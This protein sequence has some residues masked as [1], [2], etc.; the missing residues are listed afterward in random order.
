MSK[1]CDRAMCT[2]DHILQVYDKLEKFWKKVATHWIVPF[3][4]TV[5]R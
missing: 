4:P 2:N 3:V 1:C 5:L